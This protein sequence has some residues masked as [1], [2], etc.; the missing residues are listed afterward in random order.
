[1]SNYKLLYLIWLLPASFVFLILHQTTVFYGIVDTYDNGKSYTAE[2]VDF[3]L[4]QIAAQTNGYIILKFETAEGETVQQQLSLPVEMAGALQKIRV[5]PVRYQKGA[6][7]NIV[8]IPTYGT[9]KGL[10]LTNIAMAAVGLFIALFVAWLVQKYV[11]RKISG[12]DEQ[13]VIERI[14]HD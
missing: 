7:Q 11:R 10:I 14:D 1:M 5:V 13:L 9:H 3:E 4:K 12:R 6:F 2:V 8:M